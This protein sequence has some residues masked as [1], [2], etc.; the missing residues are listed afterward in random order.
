MDVEEVMRVIEEH[1]VQVVDL[2]FMDLPGQWQHFSVPTEKVTPESLE[3]GFGIDGSSVR[4]WQA[5]N[6]SDMVIFP[7]A[8]TAVMDPFS[9]TPT[10]IMNCT[11]ADPVTKENYA[12]DPRFTAIKAERYLR[13]TGIGDTAYFG[14]EPEFFVFDDVRYDTRSNESYYHVDSVEGHWNTG[15]KE[16][17]NLAYKIRSKEGYFPVPPADSMQ[18]LRNEM[19][20][21]MQ[22]C[23][24]DVECHHHE[25]A[26]GGQAEIDLKYDT[27]VRIADGLLLY[28]YIVKNV[29]RCHGRAA[30]FMPKPIFGDNGSGMHVHFSIW[31]DTKPLFAG[32][33]YAGMSEV[34]MWAL[35]GL[36]QHGKALVAITSP[37][38]NSYRRLVPGYEAPVNLAYSSRNRSV[39]IRIP[40]VATNPA[41]RRIEFRCPDP[42]CN[43][44]FAFSAMLMAA[45]DGIK[46]KID[47]GEA[48]D[49]NIYELPPQELA[50]VPSTPGSLE[51]ALEELERDHEFLL[52]GDVFTQ[53]VVNTWI[54]WKWEN[55]VIPVKSRP[56][57]YEF[58]LYFDL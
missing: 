45:I 10:L 9:E 4:G 49:K 8:E 54:S 30:T 6:E 34:G 15:R 48:L 33:D 19:M 26:S 31:K 25:V 22:K 1:S 55:E 20:Q 39:A 44:Y 16:E 14:P 50:R 29:A 47:P 12:R 57:P 27:L 24:L 7:D 46:N 58:D 13:T 28:K 18:E 40:M 23:G 52:Q 38:Y 51:E 35:G 43:A 42:S 2:R 53:D 5:I 17:P 3:Q 21:T 37:T 11:I 32:D 56:H 41:S 36:L